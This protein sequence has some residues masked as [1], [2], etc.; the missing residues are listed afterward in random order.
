VIQRADPGQT[1]FT[2]VA[3]GTAPTATFQVTPPSYAPN[4]GAVI[5]ATA[6]TGNMIREAGVTVTVS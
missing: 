5:H 4:A 6:T 1:E 2:A 3:P